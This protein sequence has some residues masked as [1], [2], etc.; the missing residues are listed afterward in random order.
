[1]RHLHDKAAGLL[2]DGAAQ[3]DAWA[4]VDAGLTAHE[5]PIVE[6]PRVRRDGWNA[7]Y[8]AGT[9]KIKEARHGYD[10]HGKN[11][12]GNRVDRIPFHIRHPSP[13]TSI[14]RVENFTEQ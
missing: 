4:V 8:P 3:Q 13:G 12:A 10:Q 1:N 6:H 9:S 5:G 11:A 2:I 7:A 14:G